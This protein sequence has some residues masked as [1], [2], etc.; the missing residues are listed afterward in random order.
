M[1]H[2]VVALL[3]FFCNAEYQRDLMSGVLFTNTPHYYRKGTASGQSDD[4]ESCIS[5]FNAE[6]HTARPKIVIDGKLLDVSDANEI[7]V[8]RDDDKIDA[9]LHCWTIIEKPES[10]EELVSLKRDLKR[11]K[12]EFGPW[13]VVLSM[14][15][16]AQF[17]TILHEDIPESYR[18]AS[19]EYVSQGVNRSLFHKS[20]EFS[21]QREYRLAIGRL[22]KGH[23]EPRRFQVRSLAALLLQDPWLQVTIGE[24]KH[25]ILRPGG[26]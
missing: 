12:S 22:P 23:E 1:A 6:K 10:L 14:E 21:Y 7:L 18:G 5:Y 26:A 17:C 8:Y 24:E 25:V 9:W 16:Y 3:K 2:E 11:I 19:V 20:A 13:Y 4:F 15:N